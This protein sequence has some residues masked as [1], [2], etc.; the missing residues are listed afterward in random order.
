[1]RKGIDGLSGIVRGVF[2]ADPLDGSLYLFINRR[3]D[4]MKA[5]HFD[6]GGYW[7]YYRLLEA[8]TFEGIGSEDAYIQIDTTQLA[9]LLGGVSLVGI[10]K[11]KRY[12][13]AS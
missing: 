7:L 13:R 6:G 4:R 5:L 1:M 2:G 10:R 12:Q 9:M 11:R 3:R 8:G